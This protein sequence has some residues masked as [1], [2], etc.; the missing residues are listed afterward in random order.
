[1]EADERRIVGQALGQPGG[2]ARLH[3]QLQDHHGRQAVAGLAAG[4]QALDLAL[5]AQRQQGH[6]ADHVVHLLGALGAGLHR[7]TDA[8][9]VARQRLHLLHRGGRVAL[10]QLQ[11]LFGQRLLL[12]R[13]QRRLG[14][15]VGL[16]IGQRRQQLVDRGLVHQGLHGRAAGHL[17]VVVG[18]GKGALQEHA[19]VQVPQ[20]EA[21][22]GKA[23][24]QCRAQR[25]MR[26]RGLVHQRRCGIGRHGRHD[27]LQLG[28]MH[29]PQADD[30]LGEPV[31]HLFEVGVR[32][33]ATPAA[34]AG[35]E[36]G[37][38][39]SAG[40]A[41]ANLGRRCG[42]RRV[43][44][45]HGHPGNAEQEPDR[46][47]AGKAGQ[48]PEKHRPHGTGAPADQQQHQCAEAQHPGH[49]PVHMADVSLALAVALLPCRV[50]G[51]A[52]LA[53]RGACVPLQHRVPLCL[54]CSALPWHRRAA[55][56][57]IGGL[58][59]RRLTTHPPPSCPTW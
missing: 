30:D 29:Q 11:H 55:W 27:A 37:R 58:L 48:R 16:A 9:V 47:A 53:G 45:G 42:G 49:R 21:L 3:P 22:D 38:R 34:T 43:A 57:Y 35:L 13:R 33:Q 40:I 4:S 52:G 10:G 59:S 14:G 26:G 1:M 56:R 5:G 41:G 24:D 15:R 2:V 19:R 23:D 7:R 46:P 25:H 50:S 36:A 6:A 18:P 32:A 31:G 20:K 39:G 12:H 54:V 51:R 44:L 8:L 28:Q 17:Q